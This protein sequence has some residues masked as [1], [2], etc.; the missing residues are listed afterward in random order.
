MFNSAQSA[1]VTAIASLDTI[2]CKD[3]N[4]RTQCFSYAVISATYTFHPGWYFGSKI[5]FFNDLDCS[6][7]INFILP[8]IL[9][10]SCDMTSLCLRLV[11]VY[12][13]LAANAVIFPPLPE[14]VLSRFYPQDMTPP[15]GT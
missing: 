14:S 2:L 12:P 5:A 6:T 1:I 8:M 11:R 7:F 9:Q 10:E 15:A 3:K 13:L 4:I